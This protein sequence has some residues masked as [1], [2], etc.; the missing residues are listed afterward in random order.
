MGA[1][2][3]KESEDPRTGQHCIYDENYLLGIMLLEMS[4]GNKTE[5]GC[6]KYNIIKQ[7]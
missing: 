7:T 3:Q 4:E 2:Y 5:I 6:R 1:I